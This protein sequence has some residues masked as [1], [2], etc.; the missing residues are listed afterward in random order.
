M[1]ILIKQSMLEMF[2]V[3]NTWISKPRCKACHSTR[4]HNA[5]PHK[6]LLPPF[7]SWLIRQLGVVCQGVT[8]SDSILF[9]FI[10]GLRIR[11]KKVA[12]ITQTCLWTDAEH[13]WIYDQE[14]RLK[15]S[16]NSEVCRH[17]ERRVIASEHGRTCLTQQVV[18]CCKPYPRLSIYSKLIVFKCIL[19]YSETGRVTL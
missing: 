10:K 2:Q 6:T 15:E 16:W 4:G 18:S 9:S 14:M 17:F 5:S 12:M 11:H 19:F 8:K 3:T 7:F 13:A 1:L